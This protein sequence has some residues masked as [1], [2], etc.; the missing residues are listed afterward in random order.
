MAAAVKPTPAYRHC[1]RIAQDHYRER[2][3]RLLMPWQLG[4]AASAVLAFAAHVEM[5]A[6]KAEKDALH[7]WRD[8]LQ[9][10]SRPLQTPLQQAL[11]DSIQRHR[12][13]VDAFLSLVEAAEI[14][15]QAPHFD[16]LGEQMHYVRLAANPVGRLL[17]HLRGIDDGQ[18][19]AQM[20]ALCC[21]LKQLDIALRLGHDA[22]HNRI[23]LPRDE[24]HRFEVSEQQL[25]ECQGDFALRR[26]MQRHLQR[27][28]TLLNSGAP[29][30]KNL[31]LLRG[32]GL[33]LA[34]LRGAHLMHLLQ[35]QG[36]AVFTPLHLRPADWVVLSWKA[37]KGGF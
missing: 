34:L 24:M 20:D 27:A 12:L 26:L 2:G 13:P 8:W 37:L 5:L 33:R 16:T 1:R 25:L 22:R 36:D 3:L 15:S 10:D 29:L 35:S 30:G 18:R 23:L 21:G 4:P 28:H 14:E 31:G 32:F 7:A 19:R 9:A 17:L 11:D 6:E